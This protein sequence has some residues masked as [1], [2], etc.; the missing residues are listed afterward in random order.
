MKKLLVSLLMLIVLFPTFVFADNIEYKKESFKEALEKEGI[1][2]N[3]GYAETSN[4]AVIYVFRGDG[5]PHCVQL[6]KFLNELS[7][8]E[9]GSKFK[10]EVYEVWHN[11]NNRRLMKQVGLE[12]GK[13]ASGVPFF[14]IGKTGMS[15][16][17]ESFNDEIKKLIDAEYQNT[18]KTN[19]VEIAKPKVGKNNQETNN[20]NEKNTTNSNNDNLQ[21]IYF[22]II[23]AALGGVI[24]I[25]DYRRK[26]A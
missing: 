5:C 3:S 23:I 14:V 7:K 4:Q 6:L 17:A 22:L 2:L 20:I 8:T 11:D 25:V 24:Y 13:N 10:V 19:I 18:N 16:Y 12:V 26:N 15:G 21:G 9:Y 1:T